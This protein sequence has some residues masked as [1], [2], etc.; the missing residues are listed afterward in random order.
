MHALIIYIHSM[1]I[2][3]DVKDSELITYVM[4]CD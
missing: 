1:D 4:Q 3:I 2:F